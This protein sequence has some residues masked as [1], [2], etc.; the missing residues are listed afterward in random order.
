MAIVIVLTAG[1]SSPVPRESGILLQ[2]SVL[3]VGITVFLLF[4]HGYRS[5][6]RRS[7]ATGIQV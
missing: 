5:R 1:R 7:P 2:L 3:G 4:W 6:R